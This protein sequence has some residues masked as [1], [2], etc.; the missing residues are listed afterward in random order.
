MVDLSYEAF[1]ASLNHIAFEHFKFCPSLT[2]ANILENYERMKI[3]FSVRLA[4]E[5]RVWSRM[6]FNLVFDAS[7]PILS[8]LAYFDLKWYIRARL[9]FYWD[10]LYENF[11]CIIEFGTS[12][13]MKK[14]SPFAH[15]KFRINLE[16]LIGRLE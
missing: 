15:M 11:E 9:T 1:C 4:L 2:S 12:N 7:R 13:L 5:H 16:Y 10:N 14:N 3:I 8:P 6:I